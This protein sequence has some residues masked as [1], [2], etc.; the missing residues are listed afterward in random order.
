MGKNKVRIK[1][2]IKLEYIIF[3]LLITI[4]LNKNNAYAQITERERPDEWKNLIYG[5]RFMDRFLPIQPIGMLTEGV[6]GADNVVPRYIDNG[7]E[8]NIWSYWG[9]NIIKGNDDKYHLFVCRWL[10]DS[11]KGHMQWPKSIVVH[12]VSDTPFGP[13]KVKETVGPGHNPE[14]FQLKDGRYVVYVIDGRYISNNINGP[15]EYSKFK[16]NKRDRPIIEGLTNLSFAKREDSSYIMVCRGGGIWFSKDGL[17]PYNQITYKRVYPA[18]EGHFEDPLIWKTNIQYHMIVNDWLGRIA[19]Y[20]RSKDGVHWKVDTGEAYLPGITK[21]T[22]GT[23]EDWFKYERIKVL[24]DKLGRAT[25][26]N[27]AV[28]DTIKWNDLKND[29]HSSKNIT[30]PLTVGRQIE[31]LNKSKIDKKTK[32]IKLL[33]KAESGFNPH[34]DIDFNSLRFGASEEVNFGKGS[35]L[36][37]TKKKGKDLILVFNGS[38]NGISEN[39][40]VGKLIGKKDKGKL[41]FGYAQ[42]PKVNYKEPIL[43]ARMPKIIP[44]E[45]GNELAIEVQ[46][47]GQVNSKKTKIS[48]QYF[49]K[50]IEIETITKKLPKLKPFQKYT[51]VL[52]LNKKI[53]KGENYRF[54]ISIHHPKMKPDVFEK[55]MI[56]FE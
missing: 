40:F 25:Q 31:V 24:Q 47:F 42:L 26:A 56:L 23:N 22:D 2:T 3:F 13:F 54:K 34:T 36:L 30:I 49:Q 11:E 1:L 52:D 9:G 7:I 51:I 12:T 16:F 14:I 35:T 53:M 27:F 37:K 44:K 19:Y 46:N 43:S 33:I 50:N 28:I 6:W 21:Y 5:G 45:N 20:L 32:T 38:D 17:S 29:R 10:E 39:N 18:V 55:E 4:G 48:I 15:W 41:L 8:D